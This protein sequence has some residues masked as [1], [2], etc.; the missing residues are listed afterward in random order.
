MDRGLID[1]FSN[2]WDK[3][4]HHT[5]LKGAGAVVYA[6]YAFF[7][8]SGQSAGLIA[9]FV[10]IMFDFTTAIA[11]AY[12]KKIEIQSRKIFVTAVKIVIYFGLVATAHIAEHAVPIT[13]AF[14]DET[15]LAFLALTELISIL[16][17]VGKLGFAIPQKLLN[18]LEELRDS[19]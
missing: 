8:D 3:V 6:L 18:K 13:S 5:F 1:A 16:E 4:S 14:L 9:L 15:L 7:F 10:L 17:N 12:H 11:N 19:K 2:I